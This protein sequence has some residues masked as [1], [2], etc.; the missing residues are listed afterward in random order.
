MLLV[1]RGLGIL[2]GEVFLKWPANTE[3]ELSSLRAL[4]GRSW[5]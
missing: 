2:L 3:P 4:E 1:A 5:A